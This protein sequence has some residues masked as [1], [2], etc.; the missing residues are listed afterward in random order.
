MI[1]VFVYGTLKPGEANYQ[2]Y[3]GD[4]P[5]RAQPAYTWGRLYHLPAYGYPAMTHGIER[6]M[7]VL[8]TFEAADILAI[9]DPLE[10]YEEGRSPEHNEYDRQ[11]IEV[12]TPGGQSLGRVWGYVMRPALVEQYGG[13]WVASGQWSGVDYPKA[14]GF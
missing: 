9:L 1:Q 6:I 3:C 4:R 8:L 5:H 14:G 12:F 13:I 10:T 7:G 2:A 11:Q